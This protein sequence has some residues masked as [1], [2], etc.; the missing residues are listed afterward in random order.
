MRIDNKTAFYKLCGLLRESATFRENGPTGY[1]AVLATGEFGKCLHDYDAGIL[2]VEVRHTSDLAVIVSTM[3][4]GVWQGFAKVALSPK[5]A[6][7]LC[8]E[9][10]NTWGGTLPHEEDF[11][12]LLSN[13]GIWG[14]NTG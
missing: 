13:Y 14:M 10:E 8:R 5:D 6:H 1:S 7:D 12:A 3:D 4:D 11:N 9:I 2:F